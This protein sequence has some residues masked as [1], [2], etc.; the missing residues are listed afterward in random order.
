MLSCNTYCKHNHKGNCDLGF[1]SCNLKEQDFKI[2]DALNQ[3]VA[4]WLFKDDEKHLLHAKLDKQ[5]YIKRLRKEG[6]VNEL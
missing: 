2:L 5:R 6:K 1:K 3:E 4:Y